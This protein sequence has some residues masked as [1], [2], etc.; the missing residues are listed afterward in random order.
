MPRPFSSLRNRSR[1]A[2]ERLRAFKVRGTGVN[3]ARHDEAFAADLLGH[4]ALDH[5]DDATA[6]GFIGQTQRV[7]DLANGDR[8]ALFIG[9]DV[10]DLGINPTTQMRDVAR[11]ERGEN[12]RIDDVDAVGLIGDLDPSQNVV[13]GAAHRCAR[14]M[15]VV[16]HGNPAPLVRRT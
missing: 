14:V 10:V 8:P 2:C 1:L 15:V 3:R 13:R 12:Q 5:L 4:A 9:R 16:R 7:G 11:P 6:D